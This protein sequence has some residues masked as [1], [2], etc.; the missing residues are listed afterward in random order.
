M[1]VG[2]IRAA[3]TTLLSELK[4]LKV[5]QACSVFK[6][7]IFIL[8]FLINPRIRLDRSGVAGTSPM[9]RTSKSI[10]GSKAQNKLKL[11]SFMSQWLLTFQDSTDLKIKIQ[12]VKGFSTKEK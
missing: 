4:K 6:T 12:N 11:S 9:P 2:G 1:W 10:L 5:A 7:S 3:A 8:C